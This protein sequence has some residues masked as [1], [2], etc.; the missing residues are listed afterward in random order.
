MPGDAGAPRGVNV[1]VTGVL[2]PHAFRV[3]TRTVYETPLVKPSMRAARDVPASRKN[4]HTAEP[5]AHALEQI[6]RR[7]PRITGAGVW[8]GATHTRST[9]SLPTVATRP[10]ATAGAPTMCTGRTDARFA[11]ESAVTR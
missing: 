11:L 9:P 6:S 5:E 7:Y 4:V 2:S 3:I 1:A 8:V 10:V